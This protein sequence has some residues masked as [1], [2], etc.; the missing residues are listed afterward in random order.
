LKMGITRRLYGAWCS[1]GNSAG[2]ISRSCDNPVAWRRRIS[3]GDSPNCSK[4]GEK[5]T[6]PLKPCRTEADRSRRVPWGKN[7]D[8]SAGTGNY[9]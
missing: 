2:R 1:P 6:E 7:T 3:P 8:T 4:I 5:V 9:P